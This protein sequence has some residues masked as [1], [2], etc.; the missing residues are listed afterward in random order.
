MKTITIS[1]SKEVCEKAQQQI[2]KTLIEKGYVNTAKYVNLRPVVDTHWI[3]QVTPQVLELMGWEIK[4][5]LDAMLAA[6]GYCL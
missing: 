6:R 2:Q 5:D 1:T 3:V 4:L